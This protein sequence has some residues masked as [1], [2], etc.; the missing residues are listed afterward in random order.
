MGLHSAM[1]RFAF[2]GALVLGM[3]C[4]A[5]QFRVKDYVTPET[6]MEASKQEF[7]RGHFAAARTG[8]QR[9]TFEVP[10]ADPL[11][12]EARYYLAECNY[13]E[14]EYTD[15]AKNFRKVAEDYSTHPL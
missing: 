13:A 1:R 6:L 2:L 5:Q 8:F 10:T 14:G 11:G 12:G 4:Q 15:A 3:A 9:V 7:R